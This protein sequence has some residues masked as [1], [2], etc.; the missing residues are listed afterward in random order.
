MTEKNTN[1]DSILDINTL[2]DV[3][4]KICTKM[5]E[6]SSVIIPLKKRDLKP[7]SVEYVKSLEFYIGVVEKMIKDEM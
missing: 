6:S 5:T 2:H 7:F 4:K 3:H 1:S